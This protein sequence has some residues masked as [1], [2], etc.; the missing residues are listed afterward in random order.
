[1]LSTSKRPSLR[2]TGSGLCLFGFLIACSGE[3]SMPT[4]IACAGESTPRVLKGVCTVDTEHTLE[5]VNACA[6]D[7]G[8]RRYAATNDVEEVRGECRAA[9]LDVAR[10]FCAKS[11][12]ENMWQGS[13]LVF[14]ADGHP[15]KGAEQMYGT[16]SPLAVMR[17][18]WAVSERSF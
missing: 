9:I 7:S 4:T 13:W 17:D 2:L 12:M 16:C 3:E 1:M 6:S 14:K 5:G 11:P 10:E 15:L 18:E 8:V